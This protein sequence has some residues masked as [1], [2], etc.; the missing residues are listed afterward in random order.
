[1][2]SLSQWLV[3]LESLHSV[4]IDLG[5]ERV[6]QVAQSLQLTQPK[7]K[8][9]TVAG[10]NG[11]GSFCHFLQSA[12][13]SQNKTVGCYTSPHLVTYNERICLN[14][15]PVSDATIVEA[16]VAIEQARGNTSLTYFEFATLAALW[17]FQNHSL[18]YII[19]EVGLGGRLDAVNIFP[20]DIAVITSIALDHQSWLG[21]D[22]E[23]IGKEK[24]GI[25]HNGQQV[26]Y[27]DD[28]EQTVQSILDKA[29]ACD[30]TLH[31]FGKD[32]TTK[33]DNGE[34]HWQY[35]DRLLVLPEP[36]LPERS[37]ALALAVLQD[38]HLLPDQETV[39]SWM[40]ASV[41]GRGQRIIRD[42]VTY[43]LDVAHNVAAA[44]YLKN[45]LPTKQAEEKYFCIFQAMSDKQYPQMMELFRGVFD[46]WHIPLLPD[47]TRAANPAVL[48]EQLLGE[49]VVIHQSPK[50]CLQVLENSTKPGDK[51]IIW[52][53][54]FL[55]GPILEQLLLP[56][57]SFDVTNEKG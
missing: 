56:K 5:L 32:F 11:K 18:D 39:A 55:V 14:G 13:L 48:K 9:I 12:L 7:K 53:S 43:Y 46:E 40:P 49:T 21:N 20:A 30:V 3:Y 19:L 2:K 37:V 22:R 38:L 27:G 33:I 42:G 57:R 4:P 24:A 36:A 15:E 35:A 45:R 44:N 52:G 54:F 47:N 31:R 1:M 16:F 6:Q 8:L 26:Y 51:V 17:I 10:T 41:S 28:G 50:L 25:I 29:Q 23:T 34:W